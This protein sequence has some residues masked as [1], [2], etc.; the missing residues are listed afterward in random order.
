MTKFDYTKSRATAEKL[1]AKFGQT[2]TLRRET[3]SSTAYD[4]TITTNDYTVTL[5][6]LDYDETQLSGTLITRGDRLVYLST[7]GLAIV[8]ANG[9]KILIGGVEH[10]ILDVKPLQPSGTIVLWELQARR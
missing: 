1:I 7:I 8:P 2:G 9:D 4:P 3:A 10:A 5:V 6:D